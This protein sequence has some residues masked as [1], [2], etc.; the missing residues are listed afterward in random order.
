MMFAAIEAK[1][2]EIPVSRACA[3]CDVSP[4]GF[5]AWQQRA[6]S[7][8]Q[9]DDL[10]LLAHIRSQFHT[11]HET[12]GSPRMTVELKEEGVATSGSSADAR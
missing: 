4:S 8:R 5:Y 10:V 9:K 1:K 6:P 12:Y 2:T 7:Q 3:L 11:S